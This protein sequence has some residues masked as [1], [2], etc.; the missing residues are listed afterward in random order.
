MESDEKPSTAPSVSATP[1]TI[2]AA[3]DGFILTATKQDHQ[4]LILGRSKASLYRE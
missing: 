2:I 4:L 1:P 3:H